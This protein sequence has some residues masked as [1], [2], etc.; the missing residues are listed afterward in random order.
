MEPPPLVVQP[1]QQQQQQQTLPQLQQM[2]AGATT[3]LQPQFQGWHWHRGAL[4]LLHLVP[5]VS[6]V[7]SNEN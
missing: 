1:P 7:L 6:M 2:A 5:L 3:N 4:H